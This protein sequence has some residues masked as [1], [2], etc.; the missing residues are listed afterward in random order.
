MKEVI[1][2]EAPRGEVYDS[3]KEARNHAVN[4][5]KQIGK[6]F[7]C[8]DGVRFDTSEDATIHED[9]LVEAALTVIAGTEVGTIV[10][11]EQPALYSAFRGCILSH[12]ETLAAARKT[13][14]LCKTTV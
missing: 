5:V 6:V 8:A 9:A 3:W 2:Y 14:A 13:R 11:Q 10:A 7:D 1:L 12:I 4:Q